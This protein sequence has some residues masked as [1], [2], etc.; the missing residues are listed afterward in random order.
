MAALCGLALLL[1]LAILEE[2]LRE[3]PLAE[4]PRVDAW[5]YWQ[6][7]ERMVAGQWTDATP[8]L[9]APPCTRICWE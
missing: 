8:F 6:M 5:V 2:F 4:C 7:A 9:S 3:N 1:R